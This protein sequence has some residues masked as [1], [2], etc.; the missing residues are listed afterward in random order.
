MLSRVW[1]LELSQRAATGFRIIRAKRIW[2]PPL[3]RLLGDRRLCQP[4]RP[5]ALLLSAARSRVGADQ[6]SGAAGP[7]SIWRPEVVECQ[8]V[9]AE[10][11]VR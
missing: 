6:R 8:V 11:N 7:R 9:D 4:C 10:L 3:N 5:S 1:R 2:R